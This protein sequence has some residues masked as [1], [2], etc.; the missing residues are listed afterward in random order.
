VADRI[1]ITGGAG[2]I[3]LHLARRL[4][5]D[6]HEVVLADDLSRGQ[7]DDDLAIIRREADLV[8]ADLTAPWADQRL[9]RSYDRVFHLAGV[10]GVGNVSADPART[11]RVNIGSVLRLAD[12]CQR[13]EPGSLFFSSTS[14][15]ADGAGQSGLAA[16]PLPESVP[17]VLGDPTSPR[18]AY[19]LSKA[20]AEAVLIRLSGT[21]RVRV[22]RY[23][24]AYGPRMGRSHVV[25]ELIVR[26]IRGEDPLPLPGGEQRRAFCY[27][28]DAIE[29]TLA[30]MDLPEPEPLVLNIGNDAEEV[31]ITDLAGRLSAIAGRHPALHLLPAPDGSPDRRWPDLTELRVRTGYAPE[32]PLSSGLALTYAWYSKPEH[33]S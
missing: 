3:G 1:L 16:Y 2:F 31:T 22:G 9:R 7:R 11:L 29:A 26:L 14:E 19:A 6:G 8:E 28:S 33:G 13:H 10:V 15:V 23:H 21:T 24:N 32:V 30:V 12:W 4:L 27:V 18:S 17:F 20:A 5:A 25:P